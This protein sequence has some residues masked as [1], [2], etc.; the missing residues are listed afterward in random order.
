MLIKFLD[1]FLSLEPQVHKHPRFMLILR[2]STHSK[3]LSNHFS[4]FWAQNFWHV[5]WIIHS[6]SSLL[7]TQCT[8]QHSGFLHSY[9]LLTSVI[10]MPLLMVFNTLAL[11]Y[12]TEKNGMDNAPKVIQTSAQIWRQ[13]TGLM[14]YI[15]LGCQQS[16]CP[17]VREHRLAHFREILKWGVFKKGASVL[18]L[19]LWHKL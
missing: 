13:H 14:N 15:R 6:E 17:V 2:L 3:L 11:F 12:I 10:K 18:K 16:R 19:R 4:N 7:L 9:Y 5:F 8:C 1:K